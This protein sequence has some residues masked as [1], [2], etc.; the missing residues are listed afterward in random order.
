MASLVL[1]PVSG[2]IGNPGSGKHCKWFSGSGLYIPLCEAN[3]W[4]S[5]NMLAFPQQWVYA[6]PSPG[7][8][9]PRETSQLSS[10]YRSLSPPDLD[11][12]MLCGSKLLPTVQHLAKE[13]QA[14][15]GL[16]IP[17]IL[18]P[19]VLNCSDLCQGRRKCCFSSSLFC[20]I[21][22]SLTARNVPCVSKEPSRCK[23]SAF[24]WTLKRTSAKG[25]FSA[26]WCVGTGRI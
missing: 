23:Q 24:G 17:K 2:V 1:S 22:F 12:G 18:L 3:R 5:D 8:T 25:G 10:C 15:D 14:Q 7:F 13:G 4:I 16:S 11:E 21:F 19:S 9:W 26:R 6:G 20:A